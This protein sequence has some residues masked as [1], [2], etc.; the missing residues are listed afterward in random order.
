[1]TSLC[2]KNKD[3]K[4]SADE[5]KACFDNLA[6]SSAAPKQEEEVGKSA[7]VK[8]LEYNSK[9]LFEQITTTMRR[10]K[11]A[12]FIV[13]LV[14]LVPLHMA[15]ALPRLHGVVDSVESSVSK[16]EFNLL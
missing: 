2:D 3:A 15:G 5:V 6:A 14:F 11:L 1:M 8:L 12:T 13:V 16:V 4:L 10:N 7:L 9:G